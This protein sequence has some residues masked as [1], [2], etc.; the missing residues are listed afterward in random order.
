MK[1]LCNC[2]NIV[3]KYRNNCAACIEHSRK[4]G[5]LVNCMEKIAEKMGA[6][7]PITI[8]ETEIY[9]DEECLSRRCAELVQECL[10]NK[11]D[12]LLCFPAGSTVVRTCEIL[13]EMQSKGE[14]DFSQADFVSLDEW[15]DLEDDSEN[16]TH[17]L[18]KHLYGPLKIKPEKLHLFDVQAEDRVAECKRIDDFI[19]SKGGIDL[20]LL[21]LGMN[22]HLGL[23]EPGCD[24]DQY[25][26]VVDLSDTTRNVGQKYFSAP[27]QLTKGITL[28]VRHMFE[29]KLVV[30][31]VFG[32]KKR[33]IVEKMYRMAPSNEVPG[34]ILKL[35]PGGL[36]I[37]DSAAAEGIQDL[38]SSIETD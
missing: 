36:V 18:Y 5:T 6:D 8:P 12:A 29:S 27:M 32:A 2:P 38:I 34:S 11:P 23:N 25:S 31:Q 35:L 15:L 21:G 4:E 13:C 10:K 20:M 17:F 24:F 14:I 33:E 28:G 9:E 19:Y 30:L 7:L 1:K 37:L 26:M 3:C 22:G 16:C